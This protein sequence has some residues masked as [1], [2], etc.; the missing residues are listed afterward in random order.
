[1]VLGLPRI[2]GT[3]HLWLNG[4]Y[5]SVCVIVLFPLIVAIG[6]G[7]RQVDGIGLRIARFFGDMSYPLYITHYPLMYLYTAWVVDRHIAPL[8]G[9]VAGAG[10]LIVSVGV[11]WVSLR[12]CDEPLRRRLTA[13]TSNGKSPMQV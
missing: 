10:V 5:E 11:A 4:L 7:D 3:E 13:V 9:A 12:F 8:Q 1:M 2:G 6:A